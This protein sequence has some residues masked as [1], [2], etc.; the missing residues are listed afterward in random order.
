M[1]FVDAPDRLTDGLCKTSTI[2]VL[3]LL[4]TSVLEKKKNRFN[5]CTVM[6]MM[7]SVRVNID[8]G[9]PPTKT[10]IKEILLLLFN[11]LGYVIMVLLVVPSC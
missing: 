6:Q 1:A 4:Q 7:Y 11:S 9:L 2:A 5:L 10:V 8:T 3:L